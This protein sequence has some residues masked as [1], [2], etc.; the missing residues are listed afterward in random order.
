MDQMRL[1]ARFDLHWDSTPS[2][3]QT[4][5]PLRWL[6]R[7]EEAAAGSA[8]ERE[9]EREALLSADRETSESVSPS[10][11]LGKRTRCAESSARAE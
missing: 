11:P 7:V 2:I 3:N 4:D 9:E 10:A 8:T 6:V 1:S 5:G